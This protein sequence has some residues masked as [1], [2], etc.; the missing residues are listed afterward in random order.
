MMLELGIIPLRFVLMKKGLQFLHYMLN[1][2]KESMIS[3]VFETL[4]KASRKA[5]FVYQTNSDR[6]ALEIDLDNKNIQSFSKGTSINQFYS[7]N[8]KQSI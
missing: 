6:L 7:S 3:Q 1:E 2:N 5:D 8:A 4:N